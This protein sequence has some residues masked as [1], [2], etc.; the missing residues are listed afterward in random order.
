M[1]NAEMKNMISMNDE[2]TEED[3]MNVNGGYIMPVGARPV[4]NLYG[5]L[6]YAVA[7]LGS[8]LKNLFR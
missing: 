7:C 4:V 6:V 2:L 5:K 8:Q 3:L 1:K